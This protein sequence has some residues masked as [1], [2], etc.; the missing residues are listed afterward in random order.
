MRLPLALRVNFVVE[1]HGGRREEFVLERMSGQHLANRMAL[2][3]LVPRP[4]TQS[5]SGLYILRGPNARSQTGGSRCG[6]VIIAGD[7]FVVA[8]ESDLYWLRPGPLPCSVVPLCTRW[9]EQFKRLLPRGRG[10]LWR[11]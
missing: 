2:G 6:E 4:L 3:H 9:S 8:W 10:S 5:P 11:E 1:V 7:R